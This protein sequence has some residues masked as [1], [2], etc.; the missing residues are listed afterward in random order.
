VKRGRGAGPTE[1]EARRTPTQEAHRRWLWR[2]G[3]AGAGAG[4]ARRSTRRGRGAGAGGGGR[5][6]GTVLPRLC[7]ISETRLVTTYGGAAPPGTRWL[8]VELKEGQAY[9]RQMRRA[10]V[11]R[12]AIRGKGN[13]CAGKAPPP[14][15][16]RRAGTAGIAVSG[17]FSAQLEHLRGIARSASAQLERPRERRPSRQREE[18]HG[19]APTRPAA[20]PPSLSAAARG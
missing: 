10:S 11:H 15:A 1:G 7:G 4:A 20:P 14:S 16:R 18:L 19:R 2:T 5:A 3:S 13:R 12:Y 9:G 17:S 6:P 8:A